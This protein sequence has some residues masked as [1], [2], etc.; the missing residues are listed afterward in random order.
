VLAHKLIPPLLGVA[1]LLLAAGV[2]LAIVLV[3]SGG[4]D[5]PEATPVVLL[6]TTVP[7]PSPQPTAT[8]TP[9]IE[10][11][12]ALRTR[13]EAL[14]D[15]LRSEVQDLLRSG[16]ITLPQLQQLLDDYENRNPN[17]LIGRVVESTPASL[18]LEVYATG[19]DVKVAVTADT[20][21]RS[22]S[23]NALHANEL[24][25]VVMTDDGKTATRITGFGVTAP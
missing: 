14:P 23:G 11:P 8:A 5:S 6:A 4:G 7:T 25:M 21:I 16:R 2:A 17:V 12:P 15:K 1:A 20:V 19:E 22:T 9:G 13:L 10:V 3:A 24:V 18:T